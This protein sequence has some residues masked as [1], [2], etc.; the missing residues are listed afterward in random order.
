[1]SETQQ[2]L[3]LRERKKRRTRETISD[4]ATGLFID[5]GFD[6]VTIAE[7]ARAA[8]V[9]VNTIFN[10]FRTK[11]DLFFDRQ[12]EVEEAR[13]RIVRGRMQGESAVAALRRDYLAALERRDPYSGVNDDL[14]TFARLIRESPALQARERE[15]G[16]RSEAALARTL[17]EETGVGE[18]DLIPRL[19]ASQVAGVYRTLF[20]ESR[21]RLLAGQTADEI[22]PALLSAARLAFD[23]LE[24]G[25]GDYC[26]RRD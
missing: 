17:A 2:E 21:R 25:V 15:I 14:V 7:V 24:S 8:D 23:L 12:V 4:V 19:V 3:G 1:M 5:R 9:S 10:Y 20:A 6:R 26:T 16:E 11:E 13:S 22:A 18:D